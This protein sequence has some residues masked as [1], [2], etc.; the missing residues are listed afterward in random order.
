MRRSLVTALRKTGPSPFQS[1]VR[2]R[3]CSSLAWRMLG[4]TT[5]REP[6]RE[7]LSIE[8]A[9]SSSEAPHWHRLSPAMCPPAIRRFFASMLVYMLSRQW[10][11]LIVV[12]V[13]RTQ[14]PPYCGFSVHNDTVAATGRFLPCTPAAPAHVQAL[15]ATMLLVASPLAVSLSDRGWLRSTTVPTLVGM[16]VGW[17]LGDALVQLH[18]EIADA[19]L[20]NS[21][22]AARAGPRNT[23]NLLLALT[24]TLGSA[25][26]ILSLDRA[27]Q[28]LRLRAALKL[29]SQGLGVAIMV[30]WAHTAHGIITS[31]LVPEDSADGSGAR[32]GGGAV[33]FALYQR[34]L[35]LWAVCLSSAFALLVTKL[36]ACRRR[37]S[38][39][40]S[41]MAATST[42]VTSGNGCNNGCRDEHAR[43][44]DAQ[45]SHHH[46]NGG[47]VAGGNGED[48]EEDELYALYAREMREAPESMSRPAASL[49]FP[50]PPPPMPTARQAA[51]PSPSAGW[52]G[53]GFVFA[54]PQQRSALPIGEAWHRESFRDIAHRSQAMSRQISRRAGERLDS[55]VRPLLIQFLALVEGATAW[56]TGSAWTD[57]IV[58]WTSLGV[59]P[60]SAHV[61]IRALG[62]T[63]VLTLFAVAWLSV[64]GQ[65]HAGG[66]SDH[67]KGSREEVELFFATNALTFVVGWAWIVLFRD[68]STLSAAA[69]AS[70]IGASAVWARAIL[71]AL[72]AFLF[73]PMVGLL[74]GCL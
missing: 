34:V 11:D 30:T 57:A 36:V 16:C 63:T 58:A 33:S 56:V 2:P 42:S 74:I 66:I 49:R 24:S 51:A 14:P 26:L 50:S 13:L 20:P 65:R 71:A 60:H 19:W 37:L 52:G 7:A 15:L 6:L 47:G 8:E 55:C 25:A 46:E 38:G 29:P 70:L 1:V 69:I 31:G 43:S 67:A 59:Y 62:A 44:A 23:I 12:H 21:S 28:R 27:A 18:E 22:A 41:P 35:L 72:F 9:P 40:S 53:G 39:G 68:L 3:V 5:L 73:G 10:K 45:R 64:W 48:S 54:F 61:V 17:A 4:S 32:G